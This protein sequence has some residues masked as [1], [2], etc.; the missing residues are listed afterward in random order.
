[1]LPMGIVSLISIIRPSLLFL[2]RSRRSAVHP[3]VF[4]GLVLYVSLVSWITAMLTSLP[5]RK[6][7][8]SLITPMIPFVF[9]CISRRQLVGIAIESG[10]R[11]LSMST[12]H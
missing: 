11:F 2:W 1:M 7:S 8:S 5:W 6:V 10:P 3:G 4:C 9:Y 12:A